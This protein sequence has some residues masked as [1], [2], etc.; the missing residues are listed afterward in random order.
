MIREMDLPELT[1]QS[2]NAAERTLSVT[3][4]RIRIERRSR[5]YALCELAQHIIDDV[6]GHIPL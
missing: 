4:S 5:L 2:F 3:R 6:Q 1:K